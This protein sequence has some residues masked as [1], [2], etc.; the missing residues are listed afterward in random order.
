[1]IIAILA[2]R[3]SLPSGDKRSQQ[4]YLQVTIM[5]ERQD[6]RVA[7]DWTSTKKNELNAWTVI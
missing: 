6:L 3:T 2:L 1:M 4:C 5:P 7:L